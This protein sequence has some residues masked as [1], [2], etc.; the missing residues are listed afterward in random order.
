[1]CNK[2]AAILCLLTALLLQRATFITE[3]RP[4]NRLPKRKFKPALGNTPQTFNIQIAGV[5]DSG[6]GIISRSG[7]VA[8]FA[9]HRG[10]SSTCTRFG[11]T[12]TISGE[13]DAPRW[14]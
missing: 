6:S 9:F 3:I 7:E 4:T 1:M 10:R 2:I 13:R 12:L 8:A 11:S 14:L 5:S